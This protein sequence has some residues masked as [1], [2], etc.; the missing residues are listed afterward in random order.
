MNDYK[1]MRNKKEIGDHARH[2]ALSASIGK[3]SSNESPSS[4][5]ENYNS[6]TLISN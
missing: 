5:E 1:E 3:S 4:L 6:Q 2:K